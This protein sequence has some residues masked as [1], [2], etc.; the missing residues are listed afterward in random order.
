MSVFGEK[1]L[2]KKADRD[3]RE[4]IQN[5]NKIQ[6]EFRLSAPK[7]QNFSSLFDIENEPFPNKTEN[8]VTNSDNLQQI[9]NKIVQQNLN[10]SALASALAISIANN[11]T[12]NNEKKNDIYESLIN[13]L[14]QNNLEEKIKLDSII[15]SL[16]QSKVTELLEELVKSSLRNEELL[17]KQ[18]QMREQKQKQKQTPVKSQLQKIIDVINIKPS[19]VLSNK[20]VDTLIYKKDGLYFNDFI[21]QLTDDQHLILRNNDNV[22]IRNL[23]LNG[24]ENLFELI[25]NPITILKNETKINAKTAKKFIDFINT[26]IDEN[27]SKKLRIIAAIVDENIRNQLTTAE[28][29]I[30]NS[31]APSNLKIEVKTPKKTTPKKGSGGG[32]TQKAKSSKKKSGG[33]KTQ[34]AK[35]S[36]NLDVKKQILLNHINKFK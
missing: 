26:K 11:L 17:K 31:V 30:F 23:D 6:E 32:K 33:G 5:R 19:S 18:E 36:N 22:E 29:K 10:D 12:V 28:K 1:Y 27:S 13:N 7:D 34:K 14:E 2:S 4:Y 16:D 35:S 3:F 24:D 25:R 9:Y 8:A 15:L 21:A 20:G